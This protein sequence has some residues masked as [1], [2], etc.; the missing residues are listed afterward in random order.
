VG[1]MFSVEVIE[2]F[3]LA[4]IRAVRDCAEIRQRQLQRFSLSLLIG[5]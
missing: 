5:M 3:V 4:Y 2:A 1:Y